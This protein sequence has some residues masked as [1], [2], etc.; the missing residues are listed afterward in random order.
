M[1]SF[2]NPQAFLL[3]ILIPVIAILRKL[4]VFSRISFSLTLGDWEGKSFSWNF[5]VRKV[6]SILAHFFMIAGYTSAVA[7][8]AE[9][10]FY[11][12]ERVYTSRGTDIMFVLDV[13][14]SMAARDI[15][16][17]GSNSSRKTRIEAAKEAVHEI[18]EQ[19]GGASFGLVGMGQEAAVLVPPTVDHKLFL[20]RL[21]EISIGKFGDGTAIGV[22]L[23]TA[24]YHLAADKAPKKCIVLITDGENNAGSIHPETAAELSGSKGITLY[25]LGVGSQ[26]KAPLEYTD[27]KTGKKVSGSFSSSF[28]ATQLKLVAGLSGGRYFEI[29]SLKD[30]SLA[31]SII[32]KNESQIQNYHSKITTVD[33]YENFILVSIFLFSAAWIIRRLYLQ[34][35]F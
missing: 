24:V 1:P 30:L 22:G 32:S 3:L 10:V 14:P 2:Q 7:A 19:N 20:S 13:S 5:K 28:D 11:K 29:Q 27:P 12:Q 8:L 6:A 18:V 21:D 23:S 16:Q 31:L 26:G 35:T 25:T 4:R 9:P 17:G 34:E 33:Y 15:I